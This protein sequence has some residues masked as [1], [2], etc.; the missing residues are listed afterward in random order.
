MMMMMMMMM[1]VMMMIV[2]VEKFSR[3][4][5]K[6]CKNYVNSTSTIINNDLTVFKEIKTN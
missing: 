6:Y 1:M 3:L 2:P 4:R 5:V